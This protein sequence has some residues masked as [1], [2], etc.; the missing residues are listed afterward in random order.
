MDRRPRPTDDD[1]SLFPFLSII[2]CVI[3]MA[4]IDRVGRKR[5]LAIGSAGM[6]VALGV[7]T[8]AFALAQVDADGGLTLGSV[9][10]PVALVA[11]NVYVFFFNLS[12]GPVMWVM[13]GEMFPNQIRGA[14]LSISGLA[15]WLANFLITVS[16]PILLVSLGLAAAY[17]FYTACAVLSIF[18]VHGWVQETRGRELEEMRG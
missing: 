14:A 1:I 3:A 9:S 7:L 2:A 17:G 18:F 15:Q 6:A 11:A 5:L 10:G 4:T 12:W 13:L 16:F 8:V